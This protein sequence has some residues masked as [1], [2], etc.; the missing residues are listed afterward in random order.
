MKKNDWKI[1][2]GYQW[3]GWNDNAAG[4]EKSYT[5]GQQVTN[6]TDV[7]WDNVTLYAQ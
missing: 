7:S 3:A 6:L 1:C 5:D 2:R 4:T